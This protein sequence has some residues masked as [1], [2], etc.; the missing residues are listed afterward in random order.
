MHG[1]AS[2]QTA[3][4][5]YRDLQHTGKPFSLSNAFTELADLAISSISAGQD[6]EA[7]SILNQLKECV[8][9]AKSIVDGQPETLINHVMTIKVLQHENCELKLELAKLRNNEEDMYV[10][11]KLLNGFDEF[12][13]AGIAY[14][15]RTAP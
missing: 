10:Y 12:F 3:F 5:I 13:S 8:E 11:Q 2:Q 4:D 7:V 1:P 14:H 15:D 6:Q 9:Q